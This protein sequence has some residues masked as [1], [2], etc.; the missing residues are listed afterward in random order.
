[1]QKKQKIKRIIF[2]VMSSILMICALVIPS[3]A[4]DVGVGDSPAGG[5][6]WNDY[7]NPVNA[8][9]FSP[10][11]KIANY[12]SAMRMHDYFVMLEQ[13]GYFLGRSVLATGLFFTSGSSLTSTSAKVCYGVLLGSTWSTNSNSQTP[14]YY[15]S[16]EAG[17]TQSNNAWQ[18]QFIAYDINGEELAASSAATSTSSGL[19]NIIAS[20][21]LL[22]E[23]GSVYMTGNA[24]ITFTT[25][26]NGSSLYSTITVRNFY[27]LSWKESDGWNF[28]NQSNWGGGI[29]EPTGV[30]PIVNDFVECAEILTTREIE[31]HP[32]FYLDIPS[33][34][35]S[36]FSVPDVI[37]KSMLDIDL[38][39]INLYGALISIIIIIIIGVV[40]W[41]IMRK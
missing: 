22:Q 32:S 29:D 12:E 4:S 7:Q 27:A 37:L 36:I 39:G 20:E 24:N 5:T 26:Q 1:M 17:S 38:F 25:T 33:I 35:T 30:A 21:W 28:A 31:N 40:I 8:W 9:D 34:I 2:A 19:T 14:A 23:S 3:F 15:I 41:L 10:T 11:S 13:N 18:L 16:D 6:F